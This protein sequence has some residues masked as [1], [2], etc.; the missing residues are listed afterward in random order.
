MPH[1]ISPSVID[2]LLDKLSSDDTFR[3]LFEVDARR[4]LALIGDEAAK[5]AAPGAKGAWTCCTVSKLASREQIKASREALRQQLSAE[6]MY[7][8]FHLEA[9]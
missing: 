5:S 9:P 7:T 2:A 6:G 1:K 8:P 4:A 3:A